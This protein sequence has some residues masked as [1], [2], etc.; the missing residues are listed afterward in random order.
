MNGRAVGVVWRWKRTR[1]RSGGSGSCEMDVK[2]RPTGSKSSEAVSVREKGPWMDGWKSWT[3]FFS[4]WKGIS[5]VRYKNVSTASSSEFDY[6][7]YNILNL[8]ISQWRFDSSNLKY[9]TE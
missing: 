6:C 3:I 9:K 1:W 7:G 4:G 5:E 8:D 2:A